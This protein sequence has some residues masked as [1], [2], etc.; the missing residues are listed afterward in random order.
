MPSFQL[1]TPRLR[2]LACEPTWLLAL[3]ESE[4]S[5]QRSSGLR[6]ASGLRAFLVSGEVSQSYLETLRNA[7]EVDPWVHGFVAIHDATRLAMGFGGF[8]GPP[9]EHGV[10]EIAYGVV[11]DF[12]GQGYATEI[13]KSLLAFALRD[14]RVHLIRAHTLPEANASTRVLRKCGFD[15]VGEV[16]DPEDGRV[17]RWERPDVL[18]PPA[19][20]DPST[21]DA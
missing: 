7:K 16:L 2:L 9:D 8:K 1:T 13:A 4:E 12:E 18:E 15:H 19:S 14:R 11:P 3:I 10:A 20:F 6:P 21:Y 17:W 5:F